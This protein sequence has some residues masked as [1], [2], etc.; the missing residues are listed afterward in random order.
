M[1]WVLLFLLVIA[2]LTI[3]SFSEFCPRLTSVSPPFLVLPPICGPS[4]SSFW[5]PLP[6]VTLQGQCTPGLSACSSTLPSCMQWHMQVSSRPA[7]LGTMWALITCAFI[8]S[9]VSRGHL[10]L[11]PPDD[12][13]ICLIELIIFSPNLLLFPGSPSK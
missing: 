1:F 9:I 5:F 7:A 12:P 13:Q 2:L 6:L 11:S 4:Q 8:S 10:H 3:S